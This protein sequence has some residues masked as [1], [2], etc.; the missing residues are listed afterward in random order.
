MKSIVFSLQKGGTGKTSISVTLAAQLATIGKTALLD[1]DPQGNA[2]GWLTRR[3]LPGEIAQVLL[4][5]AETADVIMN[6]DTPNLDLLPTAGLDGQL[7]MF[8]ETAAAGKPNCIKHI[9]KDLEGMGYEYAVIDLSPSFGALEK[10]ALIA[11]DEV[12]T[13]IMPDYFGVDGLNI[14]A[15]NLKHLRADMDTVSAA[16]FL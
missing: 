11:A 1:L 16:F 5:Q 6:T 9:L 2:T 12:V 10:A 3:N 8:A 15:N 7:K 14:F 13:P 4:Q